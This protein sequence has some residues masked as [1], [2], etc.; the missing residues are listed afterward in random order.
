MPWWLWVL[1][2]VLALVGESFSMAL[3]LLNVA[4]AAFAIAVLAL[5]STSIVA[6]FGA[7]IV[8]AVLLIGLIRPRM[9]H[10][11]NGPVPRRRLTHLGQLMDRVAVVTQT[12]TTSGGM[13]RIGNGEFWTARTNGPLP[14]IEVG[15][16]VR[17]AY[18]DGL[19]A[20]VDPVAIEEPRA[21][22]PS[23]IT[24]TARQEER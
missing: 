7:F 24:F 8:A 15:T 5:F 12:V 23:P 11:L 19:T 21:P 17:I 6:Q 20:Y 14:P 1:L 13:I 10:A 2:G 16:T 4:I 3:F 18:V 22:D 9:L